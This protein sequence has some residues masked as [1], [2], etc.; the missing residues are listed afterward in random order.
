[1]I[2]IPSKLQGSPLWRIRYLLM[3]YWHFK[4]ANKNNR[5]RVM[6]KNHFWQ[7]YQ[8]VREWSVYISH[9]KTVKV[10]KT[11]LEWMENEYEC[12]H[13][14]HYNLF[15]GSNEENLIWNTYIIWNKRVQELAK[16]FFLDVHDQH[17]IDNLMYMINFIYISDWSR[18][19]PNP[20][21]L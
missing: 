21:T 4:V 12:L 16:E 7:G 19:M 5:V 17:F 10:L 20:S 13:I 2:I 18:R 8:C 11:C 3:I 9:R 14:E 1:M 15:C 6:C